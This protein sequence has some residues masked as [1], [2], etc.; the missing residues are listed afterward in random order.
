MMGIA[1]RLFVEVL[2]A[3]VIGGAI[4]LAAR[5]WLAPASG[6]PLEGFGGVLL[7][8]AI[9][10]WLGV[11]TVAARL[12]W[13]MPPW[14][15]YVD[16]PRTHASAIAETVGHLAVLAFVLWTAMLMTRRRRLFPVVLRI[17]LVGLAV[18]PF[19]DLLF[20]TTETD[21]YVTAPKLWIA[22]VLRIVVI[23]LFAAALFVYSLRSERVRN[24]FVR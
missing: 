6:A 3:L 13:R 17:E 12:F 20:G 19:L 7:Y 23:G 10:Q 16:A 18:L 1:N 15:D 5:R 21:S 8:V 9:V 24:T 14:G 22:I 2:L 11:V 4:Y